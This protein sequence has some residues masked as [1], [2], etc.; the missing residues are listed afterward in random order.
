M[1]SVSRHRRTLLKF[2]STLPLLPAAAFGVRARITDVRLRSVRLER[3]VGT[4]PDWVGGTRR[5]NV[6][7]GAILE[8]HT[9]QGVTGIG[10]ELGEDLL[11]RVRSILVGQDPFDVN[12]LAAELLDRSS[13][14]YRGPASADIALW[15]L[16]GKL[17]DQPLYKLWGGGRDRV[18]PYSSMLSLG[19]PRERAE[20]ALQLKEEGWQAIKYRCSFPTLKDDVALI[21]ETR[22]LVGDEWVIMADGNKAGMTYTSGRGVPW[23][24]ARAADTALAYQELGVYFLEEP[25]P[26]YEFDAIAELNRLVHMQ[27]VGGEGNHTLREFQWLL[28]RGCYDTIQPEIMAEGPTAMLTMATLAKSMGKYCIPHVG[29]MRLGTICNLHLVASWSNSPYIEVFNEIPVGA[30]T[31]PFS[32]FEN[33]PTL[34]REGYLPVPQGPGL[35]VTIRPELLA[36]D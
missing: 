25:L 32:V 6:G 12:R 5:T 34:D 27:I 9:D 1:T 29:D 26:R 23:D 33:P 8:I 17:A 36:D 21:E 13:F 19:T 28:E 11:P 24:F 22:K 3:E 35:G 2:A 20:T 15:D 16:I 30:Y 18:P 4:Y 7:G 10:P 31:Y 14:S